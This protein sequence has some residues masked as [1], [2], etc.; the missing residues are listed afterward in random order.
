M[1]N[2]NN[3]AFDNTMAP[4]PEKPQFLR[5]LCILS[6]INC[7]I[8]I[9]I[10]TMCSCFLLIDENTVNGIWEKMVVSQPKL[11][12]V[13]PMLFFHEVGTYGLIALFANVL[14]LIG[15]IMMWRLNKAGFIIYAVAELGIHF[16]SMRLNMGQEQGYGGLIF[17][18]LIDLAFII[19][20]TVN[21]KYM[22]KKQEPAF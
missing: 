3:L 19:M 11:E 2:N 9:L 8:M 17:S 21:L 5:V 1:E 6:F 14:S 18:V 15:A 7:G 20:Y 13:D 10:W 12:D 16:F 22:N 4:A